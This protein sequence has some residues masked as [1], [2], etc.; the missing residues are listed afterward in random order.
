MSSSLPAFDEPDTQE[1]QATG[2]A[3]LVSMGVSTSCNPVHSNTTNNNNTHD[4]KTM[5]KSDNI[6]SPAP[7]HHS[8]VVEQ[9]FRKA[10]VVGSNPTGGFVALHRATSR[11][12][13]LSRYLQRFTIIRRRSRRAIVAAPRCA[14]SR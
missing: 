12:I 8:S 9:C 10:Q 4:V 14:V 7:R 6:R 5:F 1:H 13:A 3:G 11:L 2:T